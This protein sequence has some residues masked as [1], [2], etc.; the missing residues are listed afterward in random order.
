MENFENIQNATVVEVSADELAQNVRTAMI[1]AST[2]STLDTVQATA[3][4]SFLFAKTFDYNTRYR[5]YVGK[6]QSYG[7]VAY[8]YDDAE[9]KVC[10]TKD[11][12]AFYSR[13]EEMVSRE[14]AY[15]TKKTV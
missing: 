11:L 9:K 15:P 7:K 1:A 6:F 13:I 5:L 14:K 8:L 12:K 10:L 4:G 3:K 2:V